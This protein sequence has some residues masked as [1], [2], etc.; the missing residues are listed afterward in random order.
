ML[1]FG[2]L[3][4]MYNQRTYHKSVQMWTEGVCRYIYEFFRQSIRTLLAFLTEVCSIVSLWTRF[5]SCISFCTIC[6]N[7]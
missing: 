3:F 4:A 6:I 2:K 7:A 1:G 5:C